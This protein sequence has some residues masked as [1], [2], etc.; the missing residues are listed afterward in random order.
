M[1]LQKLMIRGI[2]AFS[3][4]NPNV[5]E[6]DP[7]IT[8]IVGPNGTGKTTI[9]ESLRYALTGSFPPN[10]KGTAFIYDPKLLSAPDVRAELRLRFTDSHSR[11]I[12]VRRIIQ[13]S[14]RAGK[15]S[16]KTLETELIDES[17][18][19]HIILASKLSDVDQLL[20]SIL[21]ASSSL[22]DSVIFSHQEESHWPLS[23]SR[24]L[25][26]KLDSLFGSTQYS[27]ALKA[28]K[29]S[30]R[31]LTQKMRILEE[32]MHQLSK[33]K[34]RRDDLS[35]R[36]NKSN[37]EKE[38]LEE[39]TKKW[40]AERERLGKIIAALSKE[41]E[42]YTGLERNYSLLIAEMENCINYIKRF[43]LPKIDEN[44]GKTNLE[45]MRNEIKEKLNECESEDINK[46]EE[47]IRKME[48]E[49]K[50]NEELRNKLAEISREIRK[51]KEKKESIKINE[52]SDEEDESE[53]Y[54]RKR[55]VKE[56]ELAKYEILKQEIEEY[57]RNNKKWI[58]SVDLTMFDENN[59]SVSLDEL[60]NELKMGEIEVEKIKD[61]LETEKDEQR[62]KERIAGLIDE[63]K[64]E[65]DK[66][67]ENEIKARIEEKNEIKVRIEE[68]ERRIKEKEAR[69]AKID[70]L[71]ERLSRDSLCM[72]K[73]T[74][75]CGLINEL[76]QKR[77]YKL[78]DTIKDNIKNIESQSN[79]ELI[80]INEIMNDLSDKSKMI[81][82]ELAI[83]RNAE[84]IYRNFKDLAKSKGKCP[85]CKVDLEAQILEILNRR[86]GYV[87]DK[88]PAK[89]ADLMKEKEIIDEQI[90]LN[91]KNKEE[92]TYCEVGLSGILAKLNEL[93]IE[94]GKME[95]IR[96]G[97]QDELEK[98]IDELDKEIFAM[99]VRDAK[100]NELKKKIEFEI[101]NNCENR[102]NY[103]VKDFIEQVSY[104]KN[105]IEECKN[106]IKTKE[107]EIMRIKDRKNKIN[108]EISRLSAIKAENEKRKEIKEWIGK[109]KDLEVKDI[110]KLRRMAEN[111]KK[112]E[113]EYLERRTAKMVNK[114]QN[115]IKRQ[116]ITELERQI[117]E[118]ERELRANKEKAKQIINK[119]D[120]SIQI[121]D[122]LEFDD[123][124]Q[125][126]DLL[127]NQ[128]RT[129]RN[130]KRANMLENIKHSRNLRDKLV[131]VEEN[132]KL[133][134]CKMRVVKIKS[135]FGDFDIQKR[136]QLAKR[137]ELY[138]Q[139]ES[140]VKGREGMAL[141]ELKQT[142]VAIK[143]MVEDLENNYGET[144]SEYTRCVAEVRAYEFAIK[145]L[146]KCGQCLDKAIVEHHKTKLEELNGI[147]FDLWNSTYQGGD[148][149]TI[150]LRS[151]S[152]DLRTCGYSL[153]MIKGGVPVEMRGRCSA[154]QKTLASIVVRIALTEAFAVGC[155]IL[156]LD[157]PTTNLDIENSRSL[158]RMLSKLSNRRKNM[159]MIVITHDEE[160]VN[161]MD[162]SSVEYFYR[163][164]RDSKGDSHIERHFVNS[165]DII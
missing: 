120:K 135:D 160:F 150:E 104:I 111:A 132:I 148:I 83:S 123:V 44:N 10:S 67:K 30:K 23:E 6:F 137:I 79:M 152:K 9:I 142:T 42:A 103:E 17:S 117:K 145:D 28:M 24:I 26:E 156:A 52:E 45:E 20:P 56:D 100:I 15:L 35:M 129:E 19:E 51:M 66:Q 126:L 61:K 98:R 112:L 70:E 165:A 40:A 89:A 32:R 90:K 101:K 13:A 68:N 144:N 27:K 50:S 73:Q 158:A 121:N 97:N 133:K 78:I 60:L 3:P 116:E 163:L 96:V 46:T 134:E 146:E 106:K 84:A 87:I 38:A 141:G 113:K 139:K 109:K 155:N 127:I 57:E 41:D 58:E 12:A 93:M 102:T 91:Q 92:L 118:K 86:L 1:A 39:K 143:R 136:K 47:S 153:Y 147:L 162:Q 29:D 2:R 161:A 16:Q 69:K 8:L 125:L 64:N 48:V 80:K 119:M 36:I 55:R 77:E 75:L 34:S 110:D 157:E 49:I 5:I 11:S 131:V 33:D 159:Q 65:K 25:K 72:S 94:Q 4:A 99:E 154:G 164:R 31:D 95:E 128:T 108:Q 59:S 37:I 43:S 88:L 81:E 71:V 62:E 149:E 105:E 85:L 76:C 14:L 22:L 140:E 53:E 21:G 124:N 122:K 107:N 74:N 63:L 82:K 54:A 114:E 115:K 18:Q 7:S 151:D 138:R 130:T